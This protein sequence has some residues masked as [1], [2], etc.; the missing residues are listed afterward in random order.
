MSFFFPGALGAGQTL[1]GSRLT[2]LLHTLM[3]QSCMANQKS[4]IGRYENSNMAS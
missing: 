1:L 2:D 4:G 3:A